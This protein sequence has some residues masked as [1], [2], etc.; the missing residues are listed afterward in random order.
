MFQDSLFS[1]K[2]LAAAPL[3]RV[4]GVSRVVNYIKRVI[5]GN[6]NLA[7]IR[8]RG[9][10][11]E[12]RERNGRLYFGLKENADVLRC[13]VWQNVAMKLPPF[14]NGDEVICA[15]TFSAF[16]P[17]SYYELIVN[18]I[19]HTGI[20][21]LYAQFEALKEQF[22]KEGLF[23]ESR[24]RPMPAFP[25]RIAVV[26][27]EGGKGVED[28]FTI[29]RRDAPYVTVVPIDTRVQGDGAEID[30]AEAIDK[31]SKR[32]VDLIVVTR[33]GGSYEDL[34]PF[35]R[36]P[37]VRAIVRAK[38]PVISAVGHTGDVHVSDLVADKCFETPSNAANY[39]ADIG[40]RFQRRIDDALARIAHGARSVLL[41][42]AQTFDRASARLGSAAQSS[43]RERERSLHAL[44][45]RL[46]AQ[47]PHA[48]L[49]DLARR[50]AAASSRLD[51]LRDTA[52]PRYNEHLGRW[53]SRLHSLDPYA[54][55]GRGYAIVTF[56]GHAVT[57]AADVPEGAVIE[58]QLQRGKLHARVERRELDG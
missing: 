16:T 48:R 36:E 24:K 37:V 40:K 26:S 56:D 10:V 42:G 11:T 46:N 20:G 39:L 1:Q 19:E 52:V 27:A 28:F 8:V 38:K 34:F 3:D 29:V 50:I 25:R 35:N 9:E 13:M 30:I 33:G 45:R 57:Q 22:R 58:A 21:A 14:K 31:A 44:E 53:T 55:L 49:S 54:V 12:L 17:Q 6:K 41:A 15:G 2:P 18:G 51:R 7:G 47:A 32:D 5:E 43:L 4:E 23:E